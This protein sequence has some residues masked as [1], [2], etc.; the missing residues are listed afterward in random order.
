MIWSWTGDAVV[1]TNFKLK[2]VFLETTRPIISLL[3]GPSKKSPILISHPDIVLEFLLLF[4]FL[5][6]SFIVCISE[7]LSSGLGHVWAHLDELVKIF[8]IFFPSFFVLSTTW[9]SSQVLFGILAEQPEV[10]VHC[11]RVLCL[12]V[13]K[14]RLHGFIPGDAGRHRLLRTKIS[15]APSRYPSL[16]VRLAPIYGI[17]RTKDLLSL[18]TVTKRTTNEKNVLHICNWAKKW[19]S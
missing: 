14:H 4:R 9:M 10:A 17:P 6:E 11:I 2:R 3:V 1:L 13:G 7:V 15:T 8:I 19:Q 18:I 5:L 16:N 12:D